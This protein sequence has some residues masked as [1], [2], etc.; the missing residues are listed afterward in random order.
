MHDALVSLEMTLKSGQRSVADAMDWIVKLTDER[1]EARER[2]AYL[3]QQLL[4][5]SPPAKRHK[6]A[7]AD[8][9]QLHDEEEQKS[10]PCRKAERGQAAR[11]SDREVAC[12]TFAECMSAFMRATTDGRL[13]DDIQKD[14]VMDAL[15]DGKSWLVNNPDADAETIKKKHREVE[16]ICVSIYNVQGGHGIPDDAVNV[17]PSDGDELPG[18]PDIP[19]DGAP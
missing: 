5:E 8:A 1:D 3:E 12:A 17:I 10:L 13:L 4:D 14:E 6:A 7:I 18:F 15:R 16:G 2:V 11:P 19:S 9:E